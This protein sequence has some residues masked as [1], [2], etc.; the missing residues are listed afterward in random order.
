MAKN[1]LF[2]IL[3][4]SRWWISAGIA[5]VLSLLA[6]AF[7]PEGYKVAGALSSFPFVV[8]AAM[9]A[10]RQRHAPSAARIQETAQALSTLPWAAFAGLLEQAFKRDGYVV[11][12][13]N[14]AAADFELQRNGKTLLVAAKRWKAANAGL[15]PLRELQAA[16]EA[17]QADA[18]WVGL[19]EL[20]DSA[21]AYAAQHRIAVWQL[22]ELAEA[23]RGLELAPNKPG[24]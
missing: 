21:K 20:S 24:K 8:I 19:G 15:E 18:L 9:A 23:L 10:W 6:A 3:M 14:S 17:S 11:K 1:S 12:R 7:M 2:A 5:A 22:A 13:R 16:R 4:R